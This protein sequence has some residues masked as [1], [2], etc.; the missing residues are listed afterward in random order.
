MGESK[1]AV[2]TRKELKGVLNDFYRFASANWDLIYD[3]EVSFQHT[4]QERYTSDIYELREGA[5]TANISIR[6]NAPK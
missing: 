2:K 3:I 6:V 5:K 1:G 4:P